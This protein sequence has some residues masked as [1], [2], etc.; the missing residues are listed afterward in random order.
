M[1]D[2][3]KNIESFGSSKNRNLGI[4]N[5]NHGNLEFAEF[6]KKSYGKRDKYISQIESK[7]EVSDID[8][9]VFEHSDGTE[10][11]F[12]EL[13]EFRTSIGSGGFGFVVAALDKQTDEEIAIKLLRKDLAPDIVIDMFRKEAATLQM[14]HNQS[15]KSRSTTHG[16]KNVLKEENKFSN[17]IIGYKFFEEFSNY[18]CLG[19]EL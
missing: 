16:K 1:H 11:N 3:L 2:S 17:N 19:M 14:I 18:L 12:S 15:T 9:I 10:V 8:Q 5:S 6:I 4:P 13:F 7:F